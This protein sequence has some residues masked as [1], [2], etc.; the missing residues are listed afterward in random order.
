MTVFSTADGKFEVFAGSERLAGPF[1][2]SAQAWRWIDRYTGEPIS[3]RE[4]T[5]QWAWDRSVDR[6]FGG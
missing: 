5:A 6:S 4:D 2:T 3:K 1:D